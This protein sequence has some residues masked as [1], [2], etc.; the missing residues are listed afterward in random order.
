MTQ[1][2]RDTIMGFP[3]QLVPY[4]IVIAILTL[5]VFLMPNLR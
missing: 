4:L 5:L 3:I 1:R 2:P